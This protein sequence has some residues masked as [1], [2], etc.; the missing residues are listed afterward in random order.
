MHKMCKKLSILVERMHTFEMD[1][2]ASK[3]FGFYAVFGRIWQN[4]MLP[5]PPPPGVGAPFQGNPGSATAMNPITFGSD[6]SLCIPKNYFPTTVYVHKLLHFKLNI[7]SIRN[8]FLIFHTAV[9]FFR[10]SRSNE[11]AKLRKI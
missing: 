1:E 3:F 10:N 5:P 11:L 7:K 4:R 2:W 6:T 8:L 9:I